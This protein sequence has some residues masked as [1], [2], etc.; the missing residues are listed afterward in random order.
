MP[1]SIQTLVA[2]AGEEDQKPA[3][4]KVAAKLVEHSKPGGGG[5]KCKLMAPA[6]E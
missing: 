4:G 1:H 2:R 5:R 3:R 6:L